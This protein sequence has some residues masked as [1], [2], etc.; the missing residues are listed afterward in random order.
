[1]IEKGYDKG[2]DYLSDHPSLKSRLDLA[3]QRVQ[4]LPPAA[5]QWR[6]PPIASADEFRRLQQRAKELGRI[7][8][9]T[10]PFN[11]PE[12]VGRHAAKLP[13]TGDS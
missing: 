3:R 6:R 7:C 9:T 4:Q 10:S 12:A 5:S 13:D 1:M 2:P 8:R 11:N